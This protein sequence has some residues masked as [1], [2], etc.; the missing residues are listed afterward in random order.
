MCEATSFA[1]EREGADWDVEERIKK[2]VQV[3]CP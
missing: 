2:W 3:S 1:S